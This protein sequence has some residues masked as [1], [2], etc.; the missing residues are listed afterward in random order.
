MQ[1]NILRLIALS[2]MVFVPFM[3]KAQVPDGWDPFEKVKFIPKYFE[4]ADAYLYAPMFGAGIKALEGN[5]ITLEGYVMPFEYD[6]D[7]LIILS[8]YPYSQCFFCGG[9]GP[10]SVAEVV[11]E[12]PLKDH[13]K[14]DDFIR[15]TGTLRLNKDD[16]DHLNFIIQ[17]ATYV[18]K[19]F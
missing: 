6:T 11:F 13:F 8:K 15:V 14:P 4:E 12:K 7:T 2:F 5:K 17:N 10:S 19:E 9:A 16:I 3:V 1:S 18:Q